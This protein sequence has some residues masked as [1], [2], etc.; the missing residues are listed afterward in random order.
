MLTHLNNVHLFFSCKLTKN[1]ATYLGLLTKVP[2]ITKIAIFLFL[3]LPYLLFRCGD[4]EAN[5][6]PKYSS[7]TFCH[8]NLNGL[9]A[10]DSIKISLLQTYI[11]QHNY[12]II[13]LSETFLNS[14]IETNDDRI[15]IDEYNLI[16]ADHPSDSKRGGVCIYYKE[17]IPLIKRDDICTLDNCLVTEIRS[18][19]EKCFST[20]ICRSPS[21]SHDV[22][23]DFCTKFDLLLKINIRVPL[24]PAYIREVL[25]YIQANVENINYAISNFHWSKAF[26]N[27]SVDVLEKSAE[28]TKEIL[29][30]KK[31]Y[32]LKMTTKFENILISFW[33]TYWAILNRL[34]YTK[35]IPTILPLFVDGSFISD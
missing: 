34:L 19:G 9:T 6:G 29:E 21:Q 15:S 4:I 7:L 13:C 27:L 12:D 3:C 11:T 8:W 17:H 16:R 22:F 24:L 32:I 20:C 35:K 23:D 33:K 1:A 25:N 14:S 28:C 5:P 10:H 30:A 26:E 18:P 31:Y 2:K